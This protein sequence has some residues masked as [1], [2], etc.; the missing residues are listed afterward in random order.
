MNSEKVK[1]CDLCGSQKNEIF[2]DALDRNYQTG[3]FKYIRCCLCKLV[4]LSP[5]PT[6]GVLGKYYPNVYRAYLVSEKISSFKKQIRQ[7]IYGSSLLSRIFIKDQLFFW[8]KK[9]K[10]LD[11]GTGNGKYLEILRGWGYDSYGLELSPAVVRVAKKNGIKNIEQGV[12]LTSKYPNNSFDVIRFS[13]VMEHVR[14][15]K[16]ELIKTNKL[17]KKGGKVVIIIP[18][19]RSV[20]F[21]IFR[22]FWY[23]LDPP[24]HFYHFTPKIIKKYLKLSGFK[25]IEIKYI[26]SPYTLIRSFRYL[27]GSKKVEFRYGILVYPLGFVLRIFNLLK[28]S[29][30]IEVV[31]TKK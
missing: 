11:V 20:F 5:R 9:G 24:R 29:D 27:M 2:L 12:L 8:K 23:P 6:A 16:K 10:I 3:K 31:A 26:Q 7:I 22:S 1:K 18:N 15:P 14:S 4:W 17:L 21:T 13:H 30:V 19:L 28:V 25:D